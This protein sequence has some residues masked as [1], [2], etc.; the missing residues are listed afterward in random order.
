MEEEQKSAFRDKLN[1]YVRLYSFLSQIMPYADPELEMLYSFGR[2]LLP[3]LPTEND[4]EVVKL[5]DEV[6]L[7]FY[8]LTRTF[9]G[10]I[11]LTDG[12]GEGVKSPTDVG[13]KKAKE[14]KAPLSEIIETLNDRFGTT[15]T[16]EDRLFFEQ[17]K[18][19]AVKA[20]D[21][22]EMR[23]ANPFDNFQLG[24]KKKLE[25]LMIQ[26]MGEND[27]IVTR[28]MNDKDFENVAFSILS[29]VIYESIPSANSST[30]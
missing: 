28:Y 11:D 30:E 22:I 5:V 25:D 19:K 15:F 4:P 29:R 13:T 23:R 2:F 17:I 12:E 8:R 6:G 20:D 26:R 1:A 9:S 21:I 10:I 14:E 7:Q 3:H 18:E 24:L 16:E 27:D